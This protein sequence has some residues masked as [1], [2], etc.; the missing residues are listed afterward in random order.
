MKIATM[1]QKPRQLTSQLMSQFMSG[2]ATL[3]MISTLLFAGCAHR[4]REVDSG[5]SADEVS[6]GLGAAVASL[7]SP[8]ANFITNLQTQSDTTIFYFDGGTDPST[9]VASQLGEVDSVLAADFIATAVLMRPCWWVIRKRHQ[10]LPLPPTPLRPTDL[11]PQPPR[12]RLHRRHCSTCSTPP[13]MGA[14]VRW[15]KISFRSPYNQATVRALPSRP[16]I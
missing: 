16:T 13:P 14:Q 12:P 3:V 15:R 5:K 1:I 7:N 11:L 9:N 10:P 2:T 6:A 8:D 4:V